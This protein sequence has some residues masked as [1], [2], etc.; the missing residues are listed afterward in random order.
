MVP[1]Q[2]GGLLP[3]VGTVVG[4]ALFLT[5]SAHLAARSVFGDVPRRP[6][7]AL[8]TIP[9]VLGFGAATFPLNPFVALAAALVL[10]GFVAGSLYDVRGRLAAY[11]VLIHFV[12]SVI[13]GAILYGIVAIWASMPG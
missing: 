7:L 3:A 10:D 5:L 6:A 11:F 8:G 12:V 2:A 1:L 4:F 13:L 9:A